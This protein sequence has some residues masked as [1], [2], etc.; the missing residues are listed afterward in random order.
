MV[1]LVWIVIA[2]ETVIVKR[3]I[4][5]SIKKVIGTVTLANLLSTF[6]GIPITWFLS[7]FL[8]IPIIGTAYLLK[9]QFPEI[10]RRTETIFE[11]MYGSGRQTA[12][13]H[14]ELFAT[15][16]LLIPYYYISVFLEY[17]VLKKFYAEIEATRVK[18]TVVIMN[19]ITYFLLGS[20]ILIIFLLGEHYKWYS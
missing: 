1:P 7:M 10:F 6:I 20:L 8:S 2:I 16:F 12:P 13:G 15:I 5:S 18:R 14:V 17:R 4:Q 11:L 19:R 9:P 3:K